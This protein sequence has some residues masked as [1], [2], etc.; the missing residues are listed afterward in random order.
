MGYKDRMIAGALE[1]MVY[2]EMRRR[3]Y[4]TYIGKQD[5]REVDFVGIRRNEKM[6][7]QVSYRMETDSTIEREFAPLLAIDDHYPK[8]VVSMD[9][10]WQDNMEGIRHIHLA[11][12]LTDKQW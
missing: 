11:D 3:G 4:D 10:V 9:E 12:F 1:N 6:Y 2:W 8:F 5:Q 7:V